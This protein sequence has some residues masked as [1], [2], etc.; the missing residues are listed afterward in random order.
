M[1]SGI[2]SIAQPPSITVAALLDALT[3]A[4][5]SPRTAT[6]TAAWLVFRP[7]SLL[8]DGLRDRA[9]YSM[10]FGGGAGEP[11]GLGVQYLVMLV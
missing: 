8:P 9:L 5:P 7:L 1:R 3:L 2:S 10:S 6:G 11:K 4:S